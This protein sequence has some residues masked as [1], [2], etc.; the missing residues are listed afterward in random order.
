MTIRSYVWAIRIMTI[1]AISALVS[2]LIFI[3]PEKSGIVGRIYF[4]AA[5]F[6]SSAGIFNLL[7]ISMRR[8]FISAEMA[9]GNLGISFRQG[10]LMSVLLVGLMV[11]QGFRMLVWWD[12]LL[13]V[14]A[15]FLVEL[16]FLS[17]N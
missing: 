4:F 1:L 9:V 6:F 11:L 7:L 15:I 2:V 10:M 8:K 3:D 13:V 5:L 14:A 12:G 16:Y 17:R